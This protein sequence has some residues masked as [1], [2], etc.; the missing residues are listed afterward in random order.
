MTYR[1]LSLIAERLGE[2]RQATE[3]SAKAAQLGQNID[4]KHFIP[5][6]PS[7]FIIDW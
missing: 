6:W 7:A 1:I 2:P 5:G 4:R 3:Y